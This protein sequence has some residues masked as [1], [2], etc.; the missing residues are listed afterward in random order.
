M[1]RPLARLV[2]AACAALT[3]LPAIAADI[4][5][6]VGPP[7]ARVERI[8]A[9]RPGQVW[10]SGTWQWIGGRYVWVRGHYVRGRYGYGWMGPRWE[11][12][13][14]GWHYIPGYW[15]DHRHDGHDRHDH[16]RDRQRPRH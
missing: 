4:V 11:E 3:A 13:D 6:R 14:G 2:L 9:M 8:P 5:I 15:S 16:E 10:I 7:P 12:W 1:E